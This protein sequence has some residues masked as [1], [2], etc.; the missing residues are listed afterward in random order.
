MRRSAQVRHVVG[1]RRVDARSRTTIATRRRDDAGGVPAPQAGCRLPVRDDDAAE[2][3][4]QEA[5]RRAPTIGEPGRRR[6]RPADAGHEARRWP[7]PFARLCGGG[8]ARRAGLW[9]RFLRSNATGVSGRDRR[10][11][12]PGAASP[13]ASSTGCRFTRSW[14]TGTARRRAAGSFDRLTRYWPPPGRWSV[15]RRCVPAGEPLAAHLLEL[16]PGGHL[17]REQRRLD[18]VEQPFEP[19]DE[20]RLG[21]AQLCVRRGSLSVERECEPVQLVP[22]FGRQA[23]PSSR[24][25]VSWISRSRPGWPR[26]GGRRAPPPAAA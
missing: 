6:R 4:A 24:I 11:W 13:A 12:W 22:Q 23:L 16:G 7:R 15:R 2:D 26:R 5:E 21:D 10:C 25:E 18:A 8:G 1:D 17:L 20:L 9:S 19:S 3:D 14:D